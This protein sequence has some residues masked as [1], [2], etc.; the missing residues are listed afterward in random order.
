MNQEDRDPAIPLF[1]H[2]FS[3][4]GIIPG[5]TLGKYSHGN[6]PGRLTM[7]NALRTYN[8]QRP[9][10]RKKVPWPLAVIQTGLVPPLVTDMQKQAHKADGRG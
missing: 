9:G 8:R 10:V 2:P 4:P 1:I 5:K 3:L 7:A 6:W